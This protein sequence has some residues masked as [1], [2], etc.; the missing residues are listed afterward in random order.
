MSRYGSPDAAWA[1]EM[2]FNWYQKG[3]LVGATPP[4]WGGGISPH[5]VHML[6]GQIVLPH[7]QMR[8]AEIMSSGPFRRERKMAALMAP[9]GLP[10]TAAGFSGP[11]KAGGGPQYKGFA[12]GGVIPVGSHGVVGEAGMPELVSVTP[13]GAVVTPMTTGKAGVTV[14]NQ[15]YG[16]QYPTPEQ[17]RRMNIDLSLALG[18]AP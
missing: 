4:G 7:R 8:V 17:R 10:P 11:R 16:T 13:G 18:I 1:H 2:A 14:I 12:T 5:I 3:G 6:T 15:Y 9:S